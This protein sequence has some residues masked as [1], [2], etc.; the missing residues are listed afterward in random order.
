MKANN[1]FVRSTRERYQIYR[2][3]NGC[4][5]I[6]HEELDEDFEIDHIIPKAWGGAS[7]WH[8]LQAVHPRCNQTKGGKM[9]HYAKLMRSDDKRSVLVLDAVTLVLTRY[10]SNHKTTAISAPPRLGKSSIIRLSALEIA[11]L[12]GMPAVMLAPFEDNVDQIRDTHK[13]NEMCAAY[14]ISHAPFSSTRC[15]SLPT[16]RWWKREKGNPTLITA[17]AGLINH[18]KQ[19]F[20]DGIQNMVQESGKRIPVMFDECHYFKLKQQWGKLPQSLIDVGGYI[21]LLTGTPV[22]GLHGFTDIWGEWDDLITHTV[23]REIE[24][25]DEKWFMDKREGRTHSLEKIKADLTI[26]WD[27][28]WQI[29][30]LAKVSP[31]AVDVNV[32]ENGVDLGPLSAMKEHDLNGRLKTIIESPA[33]MTKMATM[34]LQRLR[35]AGSGA[36]MLVVTGH[37]ISSENHSNKHA[38]AYQNI[39]ERLVHDAGLNF[40]VE[41]ATGVTN[42][43]EPNAASAA[44][45]KR[46]RSGDIPILI[47]K[48]MGI[49]GLDVPACKV[50]LFG[51]TLRQGPL[52]A[53]TLSRPLTIW[54]NA[55]AHIIMPQDCRMVELYN[56]VVADN[57]GTFS[58]SELNLVETIEIEPPDPRQDCDTRD[59]RADLYGDQ[60]GLTHK[61]DYE[62]IITFFRSQY[63]MEDMTD[64]QII[65]LYLAGA[66]QLD[67]AKMETWQHKKESAKDTGI[68]D[69]DE[70]LPTLKGQFGET[71]KEIVSQYIDYDRD[72]PKPWRDA[73]ARLQNVAKE[74][75]GV[76]V[77]V[78]KVDDAETLRRLIAALQPAE[79][80]IFG[81]QAQA[82]TAS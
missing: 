7:V 73:I 18:H 49:V 23:R 53:Q 81:G 12:T 62:N 8:N 37:D 11:H 52:A 24:D 40:R 79:R 64:K 72:D 69:L 9:L 46:F 13:I 74:I 65:D 41:I 63:P 3:Q 32:F 10:L 50:L 56:R 67:P 54:K 66:L 33:L 6:C 25:G 43:G 35:V 20:I 55:C 47:V 2:E 82:Q 51:S 57:G 42:D 38:R 70:D 22:P 29:G 16:H 76:S 78:P 68:T 30:A 71:A 75:A 80:R 59:P 77:P 60:T 21:V 1:R 61:G 27:T 58:E 26:T 39:F 36:Q 17:T 15:R 48:G 28:A 19:S 4:C 14:G 44:T 34:A 31:V 5:G 45:I